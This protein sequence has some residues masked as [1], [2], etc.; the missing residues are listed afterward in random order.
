MSPTGMLISSSFTNAENT[1][2][3]SREGSLLRS[4][5]PSRATA[6]I[7]ESSAALEQLNN[8][9]ITA[10]EK[11]IHL[12]KCLDNMPASDSHSIAGNVSPV[13]KKDRKKFVLR[14]K[15]NKSSSN[16]SDAPSTSLSE[17]EAGIT[18]LFCFCCPK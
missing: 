1:R 4:M 13:A 12:V 10:Q 8:D 16:P 9:I 18:F 17:S 15:K 11:L 7:S 6:L 5:K 3:M 2:P 14:R